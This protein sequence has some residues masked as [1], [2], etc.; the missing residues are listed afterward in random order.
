MAVL[1][2]ALA[3]MDRSVSDLETLLPSNPLVLAGQH[4]DSV[5]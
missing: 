5:C 4:R 2:M 3:F 1:T